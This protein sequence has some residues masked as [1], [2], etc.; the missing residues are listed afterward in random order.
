MQ[1]L[2]G[3]PL[4]Q[5][6]QTEEAE[7]TGSRCHTPTREQHSLPLTI[8]FSVKSLSLVYRNLASSN[9]LLAIPE[10]A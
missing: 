6:H 9:L 3:V 2:A 4:G 10:P 8:P 7:Q 5:G 1:L